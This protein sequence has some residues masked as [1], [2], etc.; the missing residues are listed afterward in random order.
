M[1]SK[2]AWTA[3]IWFAG[4]AVWW[5]SAALAVHYQPSHACA[6]VVVGLGTLL[7]RRPSL[8]QDAAAQALN[9]AFSIS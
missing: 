3:W 7:L 1:A 5:V 8:A 4:A 2:G 6:L 9:G